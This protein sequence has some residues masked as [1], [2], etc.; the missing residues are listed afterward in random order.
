LILGEG[1]RGHKEG[2]MGRGSV[3]NLEVLVAI[4]EAE[5]TKFLFGK[6]IYLWKG[7]G[8]TNWHKIEFR[9]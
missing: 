2:E 6:V 9:A 5:M 7:G 1:R 8:S 4:A 3:H